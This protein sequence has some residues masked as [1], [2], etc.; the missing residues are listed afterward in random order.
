MMDAYLKS[1]FKSDYILVMHDK[2]SPYH[3]NSIQWNNDL[4]RIAENK[5]Q[6]TIKT[7][8]SNDSQIGI[9]ASKNA[10][11]NELHNNQKSSNYTNSPLIEDLLNRYKIN[12]KS[13][14]YVAGTMY[15]VR[16]SIYE[17]FFREFNPLQI[18]ASL[19]SGNI[20]DEDKPSHTHAW[21]RLFSWMVTSEG[22][23]IEGI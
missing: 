18:R 19:E 6:D 20:M 17:T 11:R 21:E 10:I 9:I 8:F 15:W 3:T 2:N 12:P 7:L 16:A 13:L 5:L 4:L 22:Y 1:N 23:K 14:E